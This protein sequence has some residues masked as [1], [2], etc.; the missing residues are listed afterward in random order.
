MSNDDKEKANKD[1]DPNKENNVI[2]CDKPDHPIPYRSSVAV[3]PEQG[4]KKLQYTCLSDEAAQ[5]M[6]TMAETAINAEQTYN[7]QRQK[8][9]AINIA[10]VGA[11]LGYNLNSGQ[12][13][14]QSVTF[15]SIVLLLLI[16][17]TFWLFIRQI[18]AAE[19]YFHSA[20]AGYTNLVQRHF[21]VRSVHWLANNKYKREMG[22]LKP[23]LDR[24]LYR[25]SELINLVTPSAAAVALWLAK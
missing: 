10:F 1:D 15:A 16:A 4:V 19:A 12:P 21:R 14:D 24:H 6:L 20:R 25:A 8:V 9:T 5:A 13:P 2:E 18:G 11:I 22:F 17:G 3:P 23:V 7:A